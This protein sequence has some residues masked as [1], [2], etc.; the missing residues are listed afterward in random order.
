[1]SSNVKEIHESFAIQAVD[2][3]GFSM[4]FSKKEYLD[5]TTS[6]IAPSPGD[7]A[8]EVAA[9]T[10]LCGRAL[11][12]KVRTMTCL[13]ITPAMLEVGKREAAREGLNNMVF[14]MGDAMELPFLQDSFDIALSRLAFHHFPDIE[15]PFSEMA[16]VLRPGGRLALI[17]MEAAPEALRDRED[18]IERMRDP[19]HVRN[20]NRE[21][22]TALFTAHGFSVELYEKTEIP[23]SLNSWLELTKTPTPVRERIEGLLKAELSGGEATGFSP[24]W[25]DDEIFFRQRWVLIMGVKPR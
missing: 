24:Y 2:F 3:D 13:D 8:L 22:L 20:L 16:R 14:V 11:A 18:E 10:C 21:E 4:N 7:S 5:Y 9:G 19:S 12:P 23:V 25:E 1:M 15:Q 6:R 17:D